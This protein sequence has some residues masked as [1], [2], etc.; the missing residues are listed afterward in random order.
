MKIKLRFAGDSI[1]YEGFLN[2]KTKEEARVAL[3]NR[4]DI[5]E[6]WFI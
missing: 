4:K 5:A 2:V 3:N 1:I 6:W